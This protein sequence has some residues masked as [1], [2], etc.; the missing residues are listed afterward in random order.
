[1]K[2][3][4][5][6]A[7]PVSKAFAERRFRSASPDADPAAEEVWDAATGKLS[8][9]DALALLD[10]TIDDPRLALEWRLARAIGEELVAD[11]R[12]PSPTDPET[13]G[14]VGVG[15]EPTGIPSGTARGRRGRIVLA[16][17]ASLLLAIVALVYFLRPDTE[18]PIYRNPAETRIESLLATDS[19][20][21]RSGTV[22]RWS[23]PD[24]ARFEVSVLRQDDLREI[25]RATD[26]TISQVTIPADI[27]QPLPAD[28]VLLWRVEAVLE[29]SERIRSDTFR[30]GM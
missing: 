7:D 23:G 25:F 16:W 2:R 22:L 26:L 14:P 12:A 10:R 29:G 4:I 15:A 27:L 9:E 11:E 8:P 18:A 3:P 1:M 21:D 20:I 28:L 24:G 5:Q 6:D 13:V 19:A 30:V 17:A